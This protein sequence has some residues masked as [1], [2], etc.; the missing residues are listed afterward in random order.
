MGR[1]I[2]SAFVETFERVLSP[3]ADPGRE[4]LTRPPLARDSWVLG[5]APAARMREAHKFTRANDFCH[6]SAL[7]RNFFATTSSPP[8]SGAARTETGTGAV[9]FQASTNP[10]PT[11][12]Q[13]IISPS[14]TK[15][16]AEQVVSRW[17]HYER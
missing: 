6:L 3:K 13:G 4:R 7:L 8:R 2:A 1:P 11:K 16:F 9:A 10:K 5:G 14:E 17:N 15:R 12:A